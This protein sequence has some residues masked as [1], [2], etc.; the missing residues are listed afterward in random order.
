MVNYTMARDLQEAKRGDTRT[1]SKQPLK[2]V[3]YST[4][5]WKPLHQIVMYGDTFAT[6]GFS[7]LKRREEP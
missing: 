4:P 1:S 7:A 6:L 3:D 5:N 2:N